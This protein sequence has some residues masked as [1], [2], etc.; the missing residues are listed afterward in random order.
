VFNVG[1]GEAISIADLARRV[2]DELDPSLSVQ[3]AQT[4]IAGEPRLQYVPD[5]TRAETSLGLRPLIGLR[6]AIRRTAAWHR[7]QS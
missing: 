7:L 6:E 1:S 5:V 4:P 3:I 2:I